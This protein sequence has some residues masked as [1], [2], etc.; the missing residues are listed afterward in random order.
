MRVLIALDKSAELAAQSG[1]PP[2][3]YETPS[4]QEAKRVCAEDE[5]FR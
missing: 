1:K 5:V 3:T 2:N 4:C